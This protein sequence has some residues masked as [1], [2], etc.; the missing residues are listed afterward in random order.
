[1]YATSLEEMRRKGT[2][3]VPQ[4]LP[5]A[6]AALEDDRVIQEALGAGLAPEFLKVPQHGLGMG[7]RPVPN[8]LLSR[9]AR[10][11]IDEREATLLHRS[12]K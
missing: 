4:S 8:A 1:M 10:R 2:A 6:L 11:L 9:T 3:L 12:G 5:E 7:D